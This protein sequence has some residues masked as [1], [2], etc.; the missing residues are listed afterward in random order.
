MLTD[1][2]NYQAIWAWV[3]AV[4]AKSFI[5]L[6]LFLIGMWIGTV[7]TEGR[8]AGDCK[9]AGAFRVDIQAFTCQRRL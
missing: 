3:N 8:I 4:W 9:F 7:Q 6:M 2:I 1:P 5:A